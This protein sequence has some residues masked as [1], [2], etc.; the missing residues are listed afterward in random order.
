M[1]DVDGERD[2]DGDVTSGDSVDSA[3][4]EGARQARKR[5]TTHHTCASAAQPLGNFQDIS[6]GSLDPGVNVEEARKCQSTREGILH[7]QN[8]AMWL[9][10][11]LHVR[12]GTLKSLAIEFKKQGE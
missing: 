6:V 3:S 11:S 10:R 2:S 7:G 9:M 5:E 1:S 8:N 12:I 4:V